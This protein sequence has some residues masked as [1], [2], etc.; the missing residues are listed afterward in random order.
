[1]SNNMSYYERL[2]KLTTGKLLKETKRLKD[3]IKI[4][5]NDMYYEHACDI[6]EERGFTY[7]EIKELIS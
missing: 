3:N 4:D 5:M 6:L 7:Q 2:E 1:M